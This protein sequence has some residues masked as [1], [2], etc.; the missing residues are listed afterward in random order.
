M[1]FSS[2]KQNIDGDWENTSANSKRV[3]TQCNPL[4][5]I[6]R[7]HERRRDGGDGGDTELL[8]RKRTRREE[9][10]AEAREESERKMKRVLAV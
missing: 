6:L 10:E 1:S 7:Q 5:A 9:E 8:K 2:E 4:G 3:E